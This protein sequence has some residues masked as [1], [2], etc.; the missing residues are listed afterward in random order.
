MKDRNESYKIDGRKQVVVLTAVIAMILVVLVDTSY[1]WYVVTKTSDKSVGIKAGTLNLEFDDNES[2][3]IVITDL[4]PVSDEEGLETTGYSFKITN[5]GNIASEYKIY[6]VDKDLTN[7]EERLDNKYVKYNIEKNNESI[8]TSLLSNIEDDL[9]IS[10]TLEKEEIAEFT[11]RLWLD[12]EAFDRNATNKVLKKK[13]KISASQT[14][15]SDVI[16]EIDEEENNID[17]VDD[18]G[19]TTSD[20]ET[21]TIDK[22]TTIENED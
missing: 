18:E 13:V 19:T 20:S 16:N 7:G 4:T 8:K 22:K 1:A 5:T 11:L 2:N 17:S 3:D 6:F 15:D 21:T 9:L 14:T 12:D 10:G